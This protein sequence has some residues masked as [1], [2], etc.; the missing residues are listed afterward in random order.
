MNLI[1]GQ[2]DNYQKEPGNK[3]RKLKQVG[4]KGEKVDKDT[5]L[6]RV[7]IEMNTSKGR[8]IRF[9]GGAWKLGSG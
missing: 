2:N 3:I 5:V 9:P 7:S 6:K 1:K 4:K 8:T